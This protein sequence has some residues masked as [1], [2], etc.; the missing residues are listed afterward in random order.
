M[1]YKVKPLWQ[2]S[3]VAV[4][5]HVISVWKIRPRLPFVTTTIVFLIRK[6]C[7]SI[8]LWCWWGPVSSRDNGDATGFTTGG[9]KHNDF[10]LMP[11]ASCYTVTYAGNCTYQSWFTSRPPLDGGMN[12]SDRL[13]LNCFHS[14]A[15]EVIYTVAWWQLVYN[16]M[17]SKVILLAF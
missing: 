1:N 9:S 8:G 5:Q 17:P 14:L 7:F 16:A 6:Y 10:L 12:P 13:I 11:F 3:W 4:T 2:H 15:S